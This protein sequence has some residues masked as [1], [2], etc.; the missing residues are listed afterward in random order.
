MPRAYNGDMS[1]EDIREKA[2]KA[3]VAQH[4]QVT[5]DCSVIRSEALEDAVYETYMELM[6]IEGN[7]VVTEERQHV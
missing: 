3:G 1:L 4:M 2:R 7:L 5:V 6:R